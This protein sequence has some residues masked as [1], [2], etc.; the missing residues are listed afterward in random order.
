MG[1]AR[2]LVWGLILGFAAPVG[3]WAATPGAPSEDCVLGLTPDSAIQR[4]L[5]DFVGEATLGLEPGSLAHIV[6]QNAYRMTLEGSLPLIVDEALSVPFQAAVDYAVIE[7]EVRVHL[8]GIRV[9]REAARAI[10]APR[11][12]A[13]P[14]AILF[15]KPV[16][17]ELQAAWLAAL[18]EYFSASEFGG[19]RLEGERLNAWDRGTLAQQ[20]QGRPDPESLGTE[21]WQQVESEHR[22]HQ[23]TE[24]VTGFGLQASAELSAPITSLTAAQT[25]SYIESHLQSWTS[26]AGQVNRGVALADLAEGNAR[27]AFLRLGNR[28]ALLLVFEKLTEENSSLRTARAKQLLQQARLQYEEAFADLARHYA[29]GPLLSILGHPASTPLGSGPQGS[30]SSN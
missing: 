14:T 5:K 8:A 22:A 3:V 2:S 18:A 7:G 28:A 25:Q 13:D 9:S 27:R 4:Y 30:G 24:L 15:S 17:P 29:Q 21:L 23:L 11:I 20:W 16:S 1:I 19:G 10:V 12:H 26:Q 6:S